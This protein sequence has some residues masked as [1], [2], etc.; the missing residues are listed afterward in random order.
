MEHIE[1][2]VETIMELYVSVKAIMA[3]SSLGMSDI[4]YHPEIRVQKN[5]TLLCEM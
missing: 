5:Y 4:N 2:K 3:I 1:K